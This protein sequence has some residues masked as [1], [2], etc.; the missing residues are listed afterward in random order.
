MYACL[1]N[2]YVFNSISEYAY[3]QKKLFDSTRKDYKS[4][5]KSYWE[6]EK[7]IR[8]QC[9]NVRADLIGHKTHY[10][11]NFYILICLFHLLFVFRFIY[12]ILFF[13]LEP[14]LF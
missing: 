13:P 3:E 11:A 14:V 4:W 8:L 1:N 12:F 2:I 5:M 9:G 6:K 7:Q 10:Q